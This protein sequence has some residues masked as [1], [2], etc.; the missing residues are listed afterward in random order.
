MLEVNQEELVALESRY[1]FAF[2]MDKYSFFLS[3]ADV[4]IL[5]ITS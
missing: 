1:S 4:K 3:L 5:V 2:F